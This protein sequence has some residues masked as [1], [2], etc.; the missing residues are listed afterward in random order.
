M[1]LCQV[2]DLYLS[3]YSS[4]CSFGLQSNKTANDSHWVPEVL[5]CDD[6]NTNLYSTPLL[7]FTTAK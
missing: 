4:D 1:V 2:V 7:I 5:N 6:G 3:L